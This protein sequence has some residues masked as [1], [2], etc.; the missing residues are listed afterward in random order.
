[1][2]LNPR[3]VAFIKD[4]MQRIEGSGDHGPTAKSEAGRIREKAES[5]LTE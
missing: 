5:E 3:E 2:E 4:E 1:M